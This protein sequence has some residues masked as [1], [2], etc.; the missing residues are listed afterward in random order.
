MLETL[1]PR[2]VLEKLAT[3]REVQICA[4]CYVCKRATY[5]LKEPRFSIVSLRFLEMSALEIVGLLTGGI[6]NI[7]P[8]RYF[9][10]D[11]LRKSL[12]IFYLIRFSVATTGSLF[13]V[14]VSH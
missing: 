3:D 11:T 5:I 13:S 10:F 8:L 6:G 7:V 4:P 12:V 1:D 14:F 9:L 2:V